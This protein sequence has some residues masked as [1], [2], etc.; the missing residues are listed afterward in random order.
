MK[1]TKRGGMVWVVPVWRICWSSNLK[2]QMPV[3]LVEIF[4]VPHTKVIWDLC[5]DVGRGSLLK[6]LI[7]SDIDVK[8]T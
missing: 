3:E 1:C 2:R 8:V 5:H 6:A 7:E 4:D